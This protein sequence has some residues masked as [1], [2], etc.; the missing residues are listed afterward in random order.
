MLAVSD[1]SKII[2]WKEKFIS[3]IRYAN[4]IWNDRNKLHANTKYVDKLCDEISRE[5]NVMSEFSLLLS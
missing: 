2:K 5:M 3:L 1:Y 4:P